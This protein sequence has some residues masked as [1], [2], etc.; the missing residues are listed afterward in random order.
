MASRPPDRLI[1]VFD[2]DSGLAAMLLDVVKKVAG[3]ED[4]D[5][6]A[7]TYGPLGKR[8]EWKSCEARLG[9]VVE[10]LHRDQLPAAWGVTPAMLPCVLG[11][12]GEEKPFVAV[13]K[14]EIAACGGRIEALEAKLRATIDGR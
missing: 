10:E 8:G 13:S 7:I 4:C 6:C 1:L 9:V 14:E 3:R 11:R 12:I 2:A 5:L